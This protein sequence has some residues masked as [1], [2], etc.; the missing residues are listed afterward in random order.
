MFE[1]SQEQYTTLLIY[2]LPY[3]I[4]NSELYRKSMRKVSSKD[5]LSVRENKQTNKLKIKKS[6]AK[7]IPSL[8][9]KYRVSVYIA[10][11]VEPLGQVSINKLIN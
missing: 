6:V 7:M 1:T 10:Q 11:V 9:S 8:W 4:C 5:I 2:T 3:A